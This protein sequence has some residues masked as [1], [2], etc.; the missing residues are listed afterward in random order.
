MGTDL[1]IVKTSLDDRPRTRL[2]TP[3][4]GGAGSTPRGAETA[5]MSPMPKAPEPFVDLHLHAEGLRDADLTTLSIF[6][7]FAAVTCA[8][9]A[10]AAS[11][12]DVRE[13]WDGLV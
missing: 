10:G 7:L 2:L 4:Q 12:D 13:H 3:C 9:D 8:N 11:A 6:G 5:G 1:L